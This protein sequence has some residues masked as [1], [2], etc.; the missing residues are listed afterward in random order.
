MAWPESDMGSCSEDSI[1][2]GKHKVA[3]LIRHDP[4][5]RDEILAED[6]IEI[7]KLFPLT[8]KIANE[9]F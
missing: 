1:A 2:E 3:S 9:C 4:F 7:T 5:T 8:M 6:T